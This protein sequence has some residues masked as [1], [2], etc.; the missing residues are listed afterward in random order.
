MINRRAVIKAM[1]CGVGLVGVGVLMPRLAVAAWNKQAFA[2]TSPVAAM[3][4]LLGAEP[5]ATDQVVLKVPSI[6]ADG[7]VVPVTVRT[8]LANV[9]SISVFVAGNRYPLVAEFLLP[10]GTEAAVST[11]IRVHQSSTITAV[12]KADGQLWSASQETKV[13]DGGCS[14]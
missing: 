5:I 7:A 10:D 12:V 3:K 4:A 2:A 13:S 14:G 1:A 6:A 8:A 11:R 9:E